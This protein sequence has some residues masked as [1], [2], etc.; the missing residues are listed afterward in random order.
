LI[1]EENSYIIMT[2]FLTITAVILIFL[3][4]FQIAKA[5]EYVAIVKGEEKSQVNKEIVS[6]HILML[7]FMIVGLYWRLVLQ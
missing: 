3:V 4:I 6:T 2:M 5:N 1:I 7:G